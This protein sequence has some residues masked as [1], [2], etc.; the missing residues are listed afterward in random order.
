MRLALGGVGPVPFRASKAEKLAQQKRLDKEVIE[1]VAIA[2]ADASDPISDA[3]ASADYRKKMARVF[4]R[5]ALQG[6][7]S[8]GEHA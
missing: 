2:A 1:E 7:T 6:L 3:H 8:A 5:R 4:V